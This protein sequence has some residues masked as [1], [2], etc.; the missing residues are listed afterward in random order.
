MMDRNALT[1]AHEAGNF[2]A[3]GMHVPSMLVLKQYQQKLSQTDHGIQCIVGK[4]WLC[5]LFF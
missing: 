1:G 5:V 2:S 3:F 4:T